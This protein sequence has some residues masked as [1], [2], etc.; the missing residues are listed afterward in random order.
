[1]L[2]AHPKL[3]ESVVYDMTKALFENQADLAAAHAKGKVL[4]LQGAATGVSIPFHSG[5]AKYFKE[6]GVLK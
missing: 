4:S 6:K 2:I 3:S 1:V 5:A